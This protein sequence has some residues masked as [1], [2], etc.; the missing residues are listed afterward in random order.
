MFEAIVFD[1]N[2]TLLDISAIDP[3]FERVFG[4]RAVRQQWFTELE[5]LWLIA[6]VTNAYQDFPTLVQAALK[7]TAAK[8]QVSLCDQ[9]CAEAIEILTTLPPHSDAVPALT[10]LQN[11]GFR[12]AALTNGTLKAAHKQLKHAKLEDYFEV[13]ISVDEIKRYKPSS[14]PYLMA[15]KRL[16]VSPSQLCLV[17]AHGW[18]IA[19]ASRAGL[20][21][22]FVTRPQKVLNPTAPAPD[23]H[24]ENL[25]KVANQLL[26]QQ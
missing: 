7:M 18:D 22:A 9:N 19:G 13:V 4:D 5:N 11:K 15:A 14:E 8:K 21:T 24:G 17:A 6:T 3:F 2:E 23:V 26:A 20:R 16:K 12:L 10:T 1:V 25:L